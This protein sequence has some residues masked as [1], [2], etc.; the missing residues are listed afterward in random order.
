MVIDPET[1]TQA[2]AY[3]YERA[4]DS[5]E[6][7]ELVYVD[8]DTLRTV[9]KIFTAD[10]VASVEIP[11][12]ERLNYIQI[13][14]EPL[15][16]RT[17]LENQRLINATKTMMAKNSELAGFLERYAINVK[18]PM[19]DEVYTDANG[20]RQT[21]RVPAALEFGPGKLTALAGQT[22]K[23]VDGDGNEYEEALAGVQYGR[24]EP[25][26]PDALIATLNSARES[27][28][29]EV[30]QGFALMNGQAT[31]SGRSREVAIAD[32][33]NRVARMR[34]AIE[35]AGR[36]L[37]EAVVAMLGHFTGNPDWA[38]LR[39][40]FFCLLQP[41]PRDAAD[42]AQD[43][44]DAVAGVIS[45]DTARARQGITD[46]A[47]EQGVIDDEFARGY[48]QKPATVTESIN[49]KV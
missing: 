33:M 42:R 44:N 41:V 40:D 46:S 39:V 49:V 36:E 14:M 24:F 17:V 13:E 12:G 48:R 8:P 20:E 22:V 15:I 47:A 2:A 9:L 18:P 38:E 30:A 3:T 21:R 6:I 23:R 43:L 45:Y 7:S 29:N 25:S 28:Y 1:G 27:A 10:S 35:K 26:P 19:R 34:Q 4:S 37:L 11:L 5:A 31:A 16:S 32:F